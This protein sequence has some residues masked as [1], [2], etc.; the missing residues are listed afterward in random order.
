MKKNKIFVWFT[1]LLIALALC[2][3]G[4]QKSD[5]ASDSGESAKATVKI[6]VVTSA[7]G[8]N[9]TGYNKSAVSE[10]EKIAPALGAE[11]KVV[12]PKTGVPA[13]LESLA[14]DG[15]NLIFSLEYDFEA[16]INGVGGEKPIAEKYPNTTFVIFNDNPNLKDDG[17]VRHK[18]VIAVIFDVNEAS[19]LA[20]YA[21]VHVNENSGKLFGEGYKFTPAEEARAAGFVGGTNSNGILVS[22]YGFIEGMNKAAAEF[23]VTYDYYAKYDA[24]FVDA[25]VGNTVAGTFFDNG[26]NVVFAVCG[27]V[28]DG[29]TARAKE[30][31]KLAIQV[32]ANLDAQQPGFVLTSVLKITAIPVK[33]IS[34]AFIGGKTAELGNLQKYDLLSGGTGI[35]DMS[36][37]AKHVA[38]QELWKEILSKVDAVAEAITSGEIKV[39]DAQNG[40]TLDLETVP[41]VVV[42]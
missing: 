22:S 8:Q 39:V 17:S 3:C 14:E 13:A 15:Y 34:E 10:L 21:Y 33:T 18:N 1:V 40:E 37:I 5:S 4:G 16:L 12:E 26:A 38:D 23:G 27:M 25:A 32:D 20:G 36:E 19:Y 31:G 2:A 28:G 7:A 30:E 41:N 11:Y 35:T 24:G 29:I 9:D 42:K 6:A